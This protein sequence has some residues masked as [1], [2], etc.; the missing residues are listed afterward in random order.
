MRTPD[1]LTLP[2]GR[3][4]RGFLFCFIVALFDPEMWLTDDEYTFVSWT[5]LDESRGCEVCF[6]EFRDAH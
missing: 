3:A 2:E 4:L 5:R 1:L 6:F